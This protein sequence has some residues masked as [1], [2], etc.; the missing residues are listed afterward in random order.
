MPLEHWAVYSAPISTGGAGLACG[1]ASPVELLGVE[2][3]LQAVWPVDPGA[4]AVGEG[5]PVIGLAPHQQ[6]AGGLL[7]SV[8]VLR[9]ETLVFQAV[10]DLVRPFCRVNQRLE[11]GETE[12]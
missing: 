11:C 1:G 12:E 4:I 9:I 10:S 8:T 5:S 7:E 6:A 2:A 3:G